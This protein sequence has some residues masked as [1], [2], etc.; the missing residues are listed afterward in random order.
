[1]KPAPPPP[2]DKLTLKD[3][4]QHCLKCEYEALNI[5][6]SHRVYDIDKTQEYLKV[7]CLMCEHQW[8]MQTADDPNRPRHKYQPLPR[9]PGGVL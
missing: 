4:R 8:N 3:F 2:R 6:F 5:K 9:I 7:I 1:M